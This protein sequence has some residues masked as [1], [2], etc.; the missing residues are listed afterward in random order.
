MAP[1]SL[2]TGVLS[3]HAASRPTRS[4]QAVSLHF[5]TPTNY[6]CGSP[7]HHRRLMEEN[8]FVAEMSTGASSGNCSRDARLGPFPPAA[9]GGAALAPTGR[10][11][12][13]S[14]FS[15][16]SLRGT[17]A[18]SL[19]A[20]FLTLITPV[21]ISCAPMM[22]MY[23]ICRSRAS[24]SCFTSFF[25]SVM[26]NSALIPPAQSSFAMRMRSS[27]IPVPTLATRT[28]ILE[29]VASREAAPSAINRSMMAKT[30]STPML[31]PTQGVVC[32]LNMPTRLS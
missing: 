17:V 12:S 26:P 24:C 30:R 23:G 32:P 8:F 28:C 16:S 5:A 10:A 21:A 15:T 22:T 1:E 29:P 11:P 4:V 2:N 13:A 19:V 9:P 18:S 27:S 25:E 7:A 14:N 3:R 20:M 31:T 6:R